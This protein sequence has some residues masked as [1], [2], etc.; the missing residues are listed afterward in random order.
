MAAPPPLEA[1]PKHRLSGSQSAWLPS[2][3]PLSG[4]SPF[5]L[6][7]HTMFFT[8]PGGT[9]S[10]TTPMDTSFQDWNFTDGWGTNKAAQA[11]QSHH[12]KPGIASAGYATL[13]K[14]QSDSALHGVSPKASSQNDRVGGTFFTLG[15]QKRSGNVA[16][17]KAEF[18]DQAKLVKDFDRM[19]AALGEVKNLFE[20]F[21]P[22]R[23]PKKKPTLS[24]LFSG[25]KA[26]KDT[27][28][29]DDGDAEEA[30][31]EAKE[32]L[33]ERLQAYKYTRRIEPEMPPL[34]PIQSSVSPRKPP[35]QTL[36]VRNT[37]PEAIQVWLP[38]NRKERITS[39]AEE[40]AYRRR[41][42]QNQKIRMVEE[43]ALIL[44]EDLE[45]KERQARQAVEARK[46]QAKLKSES[47]DFP[48]A[49]W[50]GLIWAAGFLQQIKQDQ[51]QRKVPV[52]E[53]V[54]YFKENEDNMLVKRSKMTAPQMREALRMETVVQSPAVSRLFTSYVASMKL[55]RNIM[56]AKSNARKVYQALRS[57]QVAGRVIFALKNVAFQARKL[58]RFW[59]ACSVRL[60][61]QRERI[62]QRWERMERQELA[63]ELSKWE[64]PPTH[65]HAGQRISSASLTLEDRVTM[66]MIPKV[67]R[68]TFL[69]H[70]MRARRYFLLPAIANWEEDCTKWQEDYAQRLETKRAY[71]AMGQEFEDRPEHAF[72]FPPSRPMHL[73]PAHPVG[74]A[75]RGAI[76]SISCP[77]R[78]G[79]E[80][81]LDMWK[82]CRQDPTSWKQV[83]RAGLKE[84][85][86]KKVK[87]KPKE[88]AMQFT[89]LDAL[90]NN[91][92]DQ[93]FG[94]APETEAKAYGVDDALMP[95]GEPP[96]NEPSVS[97]PC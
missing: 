86:T 96:E 21:D 46:L 2:L 32:R 90:L 67:V 44:Q 65:N 4:V 20:G 75:S 5:C 33:A 91:D 37:T 58:Q 26:Q 59:R 77:G 76:C 81:I 19:T 63:Q 49:K 84:Y 74:E 87:D 64:R 23:S 8:K 79:D 10:P 22:R 15:Q 83:P 24:D 3:R 80:E 82:R 25:N 73:P 34:A 57:W 60:R 43:N 6:H 88:D 48:A 50:F 17:G 28:E 11:C 54:S 78:R 94:D 27:G 66:E 72:T 16:A 14:S 85:A 69:E 7:A 62:A 35:P 1:S 92:K 71:Q 31:R 70:E 89:S 55:K 56:T 97:L 51:R 53:R 36:V 29:G 93:N 42:C 41:L 18:V 52:L 39:F 9:S 47:R 30:L 68:M 12:S 95:G 45:R 61:E 13:R 40:R 38:H